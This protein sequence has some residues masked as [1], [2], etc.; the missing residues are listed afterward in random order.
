M[1]YYINVDK[2]ILE[3]SIDNICKTIFDR[4]KSMSGLPTH[5]HSGPSESTQA[6]ATKLCELSGVVGFDIDD[7]MIY[8]Q[9]PIF[10]TKK[11]TDIEWFNFD[12]KVREHR[13]EADKNDYKISEI[14]WYVTHTTFTKHFSLTCGFPVKEMKTRNS[15]TWILGVDLIVCGNDVKRKIFILYPDTGEKKDVQN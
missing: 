11:N 3:M 7:N 1:R 8:Y 12:N 2:N 10:D 5:I 9:Y 13:D 6:V 4:L 14:H 15:R